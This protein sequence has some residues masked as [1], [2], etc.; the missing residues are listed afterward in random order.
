MILFGGDSFT[1]G[2]GLEWDVLLKSDNWDINKINDKLIPPK[3]AN[4]NLPLYL[5]EYREKN[6]WARTVSKHFDYG[7][8][9]FRC[10]NGG[11]NYDVYF[12]IENLENIVIPENVNLI[13][14]QFTCSSRGAPEDWEFS[15]TGSPVSDDILEFKR[16]V[17]STKKNYPWINWITISWLHETGEL[18]KEVLGDKYVVQHSDWDKKVGIEEWSKRYNFSSQYEGLQDYHLNQEGNDILA[19]I[20]INH[21]E[22]YN[23]LEKNT[24][25]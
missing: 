20:V 24:F 1:W 12:Q 21:I 3:Y 11:G 7:Y 16:V 2:Q 10:G 4:E 25:L 13:V 19:E 23:L 5:N 6:R 8:D 17:D 9:L 15:K 18:C 22:K 14:Q